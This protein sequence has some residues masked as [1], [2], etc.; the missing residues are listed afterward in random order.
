MNTANS[1]HDVTEMLASTTSGPADIDFSRITRPQ[2]ERMA[3]AG[4]TVVDCIRVLAKSGDNIVGE[5]LR[6]HG[7]YTQWNHYPPGDVYD[8]DSG[9][10]YYYHAHPP[11]ERPGEHGHFHT[12]LRHK[13]M[14]ADI[15]PAPVPDFVEP[16]EDNDLL[17]HIVAISMD[18]FGLPI[19][20]FT[21]NRWVTGE[22]W[23]TA[24]DV[25]RMVERYRIDLVNP[26]TWPVNR[27]LTAM[28][29]LFWP[30]ITLIIRQRDAAVADWTPSDPE[31]TVYEDRKLEVTSVIAISIDDQVQAINDALAS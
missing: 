15:N 10:Q 12:F 31:K 13:G 30:Q 29:E 3:A 20:L 8:R 19:T 7:E 25:I 22:T 23:Y 18:N 17:S 24:D 11:D 16:E 1:H 26:G 4:E 6:D 5:I 14:P 2:L 28:I 9:S 27:W 21:T